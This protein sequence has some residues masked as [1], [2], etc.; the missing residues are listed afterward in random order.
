VLVDVRSRPYSR[1]TPHFSAD[2]LK[3]ALHDAGLRYLFLGREL[4]GRPEGPE[5]YDPDG[6]VRYDRVAEAPFFLEGIRRLEQGIGQYRVAIMCGE[7]D[8]AGCHRRLLIGRVLRERGVQ[9]LHLRGDGRVQTEEDLAEAD[10]P[11]AGEAKQPL[12]FDA[13]EVTPWTSIRSVSPRRPP[14]SS[15]DSSDAPE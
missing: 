12:L 11:R 1:Y 4:G 14:P 15:S 5:Y 3:S 10:V 6:K 7:E 9:V 8:P 2:P 13:E